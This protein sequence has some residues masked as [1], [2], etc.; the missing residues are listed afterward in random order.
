MIADV[1]QHERQRLVEREHGDQVG[2]VA[3]GHRLVERDAEPGR[4]QRPEVDLPHARG[5]E[6]AGQGPLR[7]LDAEGV[8]VGLVHDPVA[9]P[10]QRVG[11]QH[12]AGV[13]PLG[14]AAEPA[15]PVVH[16]VHAGH[17][18]EQH[19][20]GADVAGRLVAPDVLLPGLQRHAQR[21]TAVAVAG[22]ADDPS[23]HEPLVG[24]AGGEE[25]GV[26][27]A[28]AHR[29]AEPLAVADRDVGAPLARRHQQ[30]Q[31]RAGRSRRSPARRPRGP[32]PPSERK[33]RTAPSV[34]G[35]CT[36]APMTPG[37]KVEG[38][39]LADHDP[40]AP[41]LGAG[42]DHRD[43][44]RMAVLVHQIDRLAAR[45]A[46]RQGQRHRLRGRRRLV[47][48]RGV[49]DL[50]AG[51]VGHHGLVVEQRL[52]PALGDLGLVRR[53]GRI[54]AGIL[55]H[56]PLHHLR[57]EAA[58]VAHADVGAED[59]VHSRPAPAA[60]GAPRAR[61]ARAAARAGGGAGSP[62]APPRR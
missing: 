9:E 58:G 61:S 30:G 47:E 17:H 62:P 31:A 43:R 21:G 54:P 35:Y 18:G 50:E 38:L 4:R 11:Q 29:D 59:P 3:Q 56:V 34:A 55:Q 25:G 2:Q 22:D 13:Y 48:Q 23:R 14:D 60:P 36:S 51:E 5:V 7:H 28:V 37:S 1:V 33:S 19:L 24:L 52:E 46:H 49:G 20:R 40:D 8:E 12:R 10:S 57:G 26:R 53:V 16:G 27:P 6:Q 41:R 32:A 44:L 42:L 45:L 15:G 39:G